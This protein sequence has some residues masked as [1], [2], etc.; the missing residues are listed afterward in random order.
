MIFRHVLSLLGG[1]LLMF[2]PSASAQQCVG[3]CNDDQRIGIDELVRGVGIALGDIAL[4][5][6]PSFDANDD[7]RVAINELTGAVV[8]SLDGCP[9]VP[10]TPTSTETASPTPSPTPT[11]TP[12]DTPTETPTQTPTRSNTPSRTATATHTD[13]PTQ[14]ATQT[15]TVIPDVSGIWR[16]EQLSVTDS[17]CPQP[18]ADQIRDTIAGLPSHCDY[19]VLQDGPQITAVAC[20]EG[21]GGTATGEVDQS[22]TIRIDFEPIS[23]TDQGCTVTL[24]VPLTIDASHSPTTARY[25]FQTSFS[26]I[27]AAVEPC[28]TQVEGRWTRLP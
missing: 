2:A 10:P 18:I 24:N 5:L 23:R 7:D 16:E 4:E 20:E 17:D 6:C 14:T 11:D 27:C 25:L 22:G 12:T 1:L 8:H 15:P 21:G 26:G 3:D 13:T 9:V 19:Q 28:N